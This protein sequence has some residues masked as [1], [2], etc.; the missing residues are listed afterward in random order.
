ML[1][2]CSVILA[3]G[4]RAKNPGLLSGQAPVSGFLAHGSHVRGNDTGDYA[5]TKSL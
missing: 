3:R 4:C 2:V 5:A 1:I